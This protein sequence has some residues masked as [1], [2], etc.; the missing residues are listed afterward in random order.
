MKELLEKYPYTMWQAIVAKGET[1]LGYLQWVET[2]QQIDILT[3]KK[4]GYLSY[5]ER[6]ATSGNIETRT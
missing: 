2:R 1:T 3:R 4:E 5:I 6:R